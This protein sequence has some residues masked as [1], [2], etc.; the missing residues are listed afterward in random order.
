MGE[1]Y[2]LAEFKIQEDKIQEA[3]SLFTELAWKSSKEK[4]CSSYEVKQVS[5]DEQWFIIAETFENQ[6]AFD[7]H[8]TTKH[9]LEVLKG[10]IEP[11]IIEKKVRFLI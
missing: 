6:E 5:R 4:G 10:K 1:I 7:F 3:K 8:K 11:M 2:I 9:Y